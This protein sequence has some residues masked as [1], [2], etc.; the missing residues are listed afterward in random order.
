MTKKITIIFLIL[1]MVFGGIFAIDRL[2]SR[3]HADSI[4]KSP[5]SSYRLERKL[6]DYD[7]GQLNKQEKT[8]D[9]TGLSKDKN[10][11][12][13]ETTNLRDEDLAQMSGYK[14]TNIYAN[15]SSTTN[16]Q[17]DF[18]VLYGFYPHHLEDSYTYYDLEGLGLFDLLDANGY[19]MAEDIYDL[20][21]SKSFVYTK[22]NQALGLYDKL[23]KDH[24]NSLICI[25]EKTSSGIDIINNSDS[26]RV[27]LVMDFGF[28]KEIDN[29]GGQIDIL[30]TLSNLLGLDHRVFNF[31]IDLLDPDMSKLNYV[32]PFTYDY[33][34][35]FIIEDGIGISSTGKDDIFIGDS[36]DF[37]IDFLRKKVR[38]EIDSSHGILNHRVPQTFENFDKDLMDSLGQDR[39]IM[40]AGGAIE[41]IDY[42]NTI[43]A[44]D[45]SYGRGR[46]IFEIDFI[47]SSDRLPLGLH[48]FA[49]F[50]W[51]FYNVD[52]Q[53]RAYTY[54]EFMGFD[55][56]HGQTQINLDRMAKWLNDH[57]DARIIT[58]IKENNIGVLR[59]IKNA[60]PHISDQV[61]P[62]VY[63]QDEY[64][65]VKDLGYYDIVYTLY[66]S[67]DSVDDVIEFSM[68]E[69]LYA[70]TLDQKRYEEHFK[71]R[72]G[73]IK[74]K[75]YVH[76][77]NDLTTLKE[78][79]D[80]GVYGIYTD[81]L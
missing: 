29:L 52:H 6:V 22:T 12:L 18:S 38:M 31:G 58:D 65:M 45:N 50:M 17:E 5:G 15:M 67:G 43:E 71:D 2:G 46:R 1:V 28:D 49:G 79:L 14:F 73:Q 8:N 69:D 33:K 34:G 72:V 51:K 56:V 42:L 54:D 35:S 57:P 66:M 81:I 9:H 39:F 70:I 40:H 80:D 68:E 36:K 74:S 3:S 55:H 10:L 11:I 19:Y 26:L 44:L 62:Q 76:T 4:S 20:K 60:Y 30:Q 64:H 23:K 13:I 7:L 53:D 77:I 61:I 25:Y 16:R 41:S 32:I 63:D 75:V 21:E 37:D 78:Y 48:G 24:P 59:Q 47:L 27:D